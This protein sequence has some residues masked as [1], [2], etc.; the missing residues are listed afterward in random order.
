MKTKFQTEMCT[1]GIATAFPRTPNIISRSAL[2]CTGLGRLFRWT[3]NNTGSM[4]DTPANVSLCP[5][6]KIFGQLRLGNVGF[7]TFWNRSDSVNSSAAY[8]TYTVRHEDLT[9]SPLHTRSLSAPS[10]SCG[11]KTE[12]EYAKDVDVC[13]VGFRETLF[14]FTGTDLPSGPKTSCASLGSAST[15]DRHSE[16]HSLLKEAA[17][18]TMA[19]I[20]SLELFAMR[21][22][23][24][25]TLVSD[26]GLRIMS[27]S[28]PGVAK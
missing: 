14:R 18:E 17:N 9:I 1:Q 23:D 26:S 16:H 24:Y 21:G 5:L 12:I 13:G 3:V 4:V 25:A 7:L 11:S 15:V 6:G 28:N 20:Y 10:T 2:Y 19:F 27:I 8:A 22:W